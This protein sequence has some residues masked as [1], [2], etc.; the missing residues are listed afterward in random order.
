MRPLFLA[1]AVGLA[2]GCS[3]ERVPDGQ[4][5]ALATMENDVTARLDYFELP[6][7]DAATVAKTRDFYSE[8]F[9]W[10]FT[11]FGPDYSATTTGDTDIGL[12]GVSGEDAIAKPLPVIRVED[13]EAALAKVEAANGRIVRPIFAFPGGRRF[14]AV[15]PAGNEFAV[16]IVDPDETGE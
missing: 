3:V 15:D 7:G 12:S 11:D 14:H 2:T 16:Y 10:T 6:S 4:S 5:D 8:A 9:D 13:I 1:A